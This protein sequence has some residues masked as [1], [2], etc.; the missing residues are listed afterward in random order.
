MPTAPAIGDVIGGYRFSGGDPASQSSW[1][2]A[3]GGLGGL[4][5]G[6]FSAAPASDADASMGDFSTAAGVSL[7]PMPEQK[8]R[9]APP[10]SLPVR[11][12]RPV[13]SAPVLDKVSAQPTPNAPS[14]VPGAPTPG[15]VMDGY[16]YKGGAPNDPENWEMLQGQ[17]FLKTLSPQQA[18]LIEGMVQG[19]IAPPTSFALTKPYWQQALAQ[20]RQYDPTFSET[21][22]P[23]RSSMRKEVAMGKFGQ[24]LNALNTAIQH[25]GL[26]AKDIPEVWGTSLTPVNWLGNEAAALTGS[27]GVVEYSNAAN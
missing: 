13:A 10:I 14:A 25:T 17:D 24:N 6:P 11:A 16:R 7:P 20:A 19:D 15:A 23:V 2:P 18:S 8:P 3:S 21:L 9:G 12:P 5:S 27:P 26:L 1:V 4:N 22:W